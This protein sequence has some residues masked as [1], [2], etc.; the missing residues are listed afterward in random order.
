MYK[1]IEKIKAIFEFIELFK[2]ITFLYYFLEIC[3]S[4]FNIFLLYLF[5][6][7]V[8]KININKVTFLEEL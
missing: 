2:S 1:N 7:K 8:Y 3:I 4:I 6:D 5:I